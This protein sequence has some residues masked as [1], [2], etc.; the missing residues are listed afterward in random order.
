MNKSLT[1]RG[2]YG[3]DVICLQVIDDFLYSLDAFFSSE[4]HLVV[5]AADVG[6][7][8][9]RAEHTVTRNPPKVCWLSPFFKEQM[10][11]ARSGEVRRNGSHFTIT[12]INKC[13]CFTV[14]WS[15]EHI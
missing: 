6:C 13:S 8:L 11:I 4:V 1:D 15:L 10:Y 2:A 5:F 14:L 9:T 3:G 12:V 7:N